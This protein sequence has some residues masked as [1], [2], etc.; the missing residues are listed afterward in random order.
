MSWAGLLALALLA[1]AGTGGAAAVARLHRRGVAWPVRRSVAA[2]AGLAATATAVALPVT[3]ALDPAR[4]HAAQH[5]LG[6][7]VGPLLLA[8]SAPVTLA[9]RALP[10]RGRRVLL[11]VVHS[12]VA[13]VATSPGVVVVLDVGGLAAVYL[14]DLADHLHHAPVLAA[15]VHL[16]LFVAGYLLAAVLAGPDPLRR[17]TGTASALA[18]LVVVAAAHQVVMT[19]AYAQALT[20][21]GGP[22]AAAMGAAALMRA[23]GHLVDAALVAAVMTRWYAAT[24]RELARQRRRPSRAGAAAA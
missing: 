23:G 24:G 12:R 8:L 14:T 2:A 4:L 7:M 17:R 6:G 21:P 3:G 13:G 15:A 22:D 16:H 10:P 19:V 1:V 9:L 11:A 18:L 5:L 20:A